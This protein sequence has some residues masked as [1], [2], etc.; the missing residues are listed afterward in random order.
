MPPNPNS[1]ELFG[2][3]IIIDQ[4]KKCWLLEVN[5]SPSLAREYILDELVKQ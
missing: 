4:D 1:F 5:A 2:Y 3:D